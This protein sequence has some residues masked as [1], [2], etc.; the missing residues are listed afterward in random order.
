MSTIH[1]RIFEKTQPLEMYTLIDLFYVENVQ[2]IERVN[3][4][5]LAWHLDRQLKT[6]IIQ[7]FIKPIH[8]GE[9][10]SEYITDKNNS[11]G[12]IVYLNDFTK[13]RSYKKANTW[14]NNLFTSHLEIIYDYG[15]EAEL[16]L[17]YCPQGWVS[18][19]FEAHAK[20]LNLK[21]VRY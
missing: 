13:K 8:V 6:K 20:R 21:I 10:V 16:F 11:D 7:D 19:K 2:F 1:F 12:Y 3:K 9:I 4:S 18:K 5:N 15:W 14:L 17:G